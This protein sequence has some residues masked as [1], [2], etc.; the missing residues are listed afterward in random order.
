MKRLLL[1][2]FALASTQLSFAQSP[3]CDS[4]PVYKDSSAGVYPKPF[5]MGVPGAVGI[6]ESA[7]IGKPYK[8][9][10]TVVI[11]DSITINGNPAPLDS[12]VVTNVT[13]LPVGINYSCEPSNCHFKKNTINC[14]AIYGAAT[15]ANQP[16]DY[17]LVIQGFAYIFNQPFGFP[18]TFPG[19]QFPGEYILKLEP[20]DS[21]NCSVAGTGKTLADKVRLQTSPNP[22]NGWLNIEITSEVQGTFDLQVMDLLGKSVYRKEVSLSFGANNL[23]FDGSNLPDG[24]YLLTLQNELGATARKFTIQH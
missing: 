7:C 20:A 5:Q 15:A 8:F 14:A 24:L 6:T 12:V 2:A 19:A 4:D 22:T 3:N 9:V 18:I 11:S 13:G 1:I 17:K 23:T 16:K 10:F 21:P